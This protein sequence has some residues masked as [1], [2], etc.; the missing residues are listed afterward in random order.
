[1]TTALFSP[2]A[3]PAKFSESILHKL[4][5]ILPTTGNL[6][7][8]FAGVGKIHSL[9]RASIG[10]E[11]EPEW[12]MQ[13][14]RTIVGNALHLPFPDASFDIVCTSPCYGNRMADHH[15]AQERCAFC[16]ATGVVGHERGLPT[17]TICPKC[18]G[19]KKRDYKRHTYRH[20]LGRDL[21]DNSSA[22]MQWGNAY[23]AFHAS[24]WAEVRRVLGRGGLFVLNISD[25]HRGGCVE[26]V[27]AWHVKTLRRLGFVPQRL[28]KIET[29]RMNQGENYHLRCEF[30]YVIEFIG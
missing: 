22:V 27:S 3:H 26:P 1:M 14:N 4:D 13:H 17:G 19:A 25:H 21:S 20:Y 28:H 7:D 29:P 11:L 2:P 6:L 23:R 9:G 16:W 30:E 5:E 18:N 24:A 10:V 8:P 12:A 15:H